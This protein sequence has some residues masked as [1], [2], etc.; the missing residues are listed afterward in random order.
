MRGLFTI[1]L[2]MLAM[3]F[4]Y[5]QQ[6]EESITSRL[7]LQMDDYR[8]GKAS[9]LNGKAFEGSGTMQLKSSGTEK[10][11]SFNGSK[12]FGGSDSFTTRS[13]LGLK[14]PWF[15]KKVYASDSASLWSKSLVGNADKKYAVSTAPE[16][17][18]K[19]AKKAAQKSNSEV[20]QKPFLARGAA[21]GALD[22]AKSKKDLTI[23]DVRSIL[24]KNH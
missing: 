22:E 17:G 21:Q 5:G 24:N 10:A 20:E 11:S 15:G 7:K 13:F 6:Q 4:C 8:N 12:K 2:W 1:T 18:Y 14:N 16:K 3:A 19:D 9:P 23:D